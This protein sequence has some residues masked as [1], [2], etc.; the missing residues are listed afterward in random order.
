MSKPRQSPY[1]ICRR[2]GDRWVDHGR[3]DIRDLASDVAW[4]ARCYPGDLKVVNTDTGA[5]VI[6]S[7]KELAGIVEVL[8]LA[9]IT[10]RNHHDRA[11]I[12]A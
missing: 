5:A 8:R 4:V 11:E 3:S 1:L 10:V 7:A 12:S 2:C 9:K 6:G